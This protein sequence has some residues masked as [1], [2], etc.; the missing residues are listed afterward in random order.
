MDRGP[1]NPTNVEEK[2]SQFNLDITV[3]LISDPFILITM[4]FRCFVED[5]IREVLFLILNLITPQKNQYLENLIHIRLKSL[6]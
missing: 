6:S 5:K 3:T 1:S 4:S 2:S